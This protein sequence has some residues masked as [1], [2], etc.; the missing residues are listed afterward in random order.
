MSAE[1]KCT[2]CDKLCSS[3][4]KGKPFLLCVDCYKE[5]YSLDLAIARRYV[6]EHADHIVDNI[7]L[8]PEGTTIGEKW[9]RDHNI[10]KVLTVAAHMERMTKFKGIEY[11]QFNVDD[12]P[13][14]SLRPLFQIAFDFI[15]KD[16]KSNVLVHCV[17]GISRSGTIVIAYCMK[18][19]SLDYEEALKFVR[20]KRKIVSPNSGFQRQLREYEK[21][22]LSKKNT[23]VKDENI[24]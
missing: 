15:Q 2:L 10:R 16:P 23:K 8:G 19:L 5:A 9:L 1:L 4:Q 14:E 3:D 7:F 12:D 13:S 24:E 21:E 11:K 22:L 20:K 18:T 6:F 17:S